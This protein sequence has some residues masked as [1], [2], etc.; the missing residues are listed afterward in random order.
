MDSRFSIHFSVKI[1]ICWWKIFPNWRKLIMLSFTLQRMS[2]IKFQNSFRFHLVYF[3]IESFS[4]QFLQ[5]FLFNSCLYFDI[6]VISFLIFLAFIDPKYWES[7]V[8]ATVKLQP[9][10]LRVA[11]SSSSKTESTLFCTSRNYKLFTMCRRCFPKF[12]L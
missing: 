11:P 9:P 2:S 12:S 5:F 10:L 7:F 3:Y 8:I 6:F 1:S 4:K